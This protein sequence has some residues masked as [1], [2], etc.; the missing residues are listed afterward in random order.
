MD[1]LLFEVK[2]PVHLFPRFERCKFE[3]FEWFVRRDQCFD[4]MLLEM[5]KH[6]I[7]WL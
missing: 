1:H 3:E 6:G 7:N 5:A 2:I 4:D